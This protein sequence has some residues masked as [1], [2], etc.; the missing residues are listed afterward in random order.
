MNFCA[1]LAPAS[2]WSCVS[3]KILDC[4][5]GNSVLSKQTMVIKI[6]SV[7]MHRWTLRRCFLLTYVRQCQVSYRIFCLPTFSSCSLLRFFIPQIAETQSTHSLVGLK[8]RSSSAQCLLP[9]CSFSLC[10]DVVRH[11]TLFLPL[12]QTVWLIYI[13][14]CNSKFIIWIIRSQ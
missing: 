8:I 10:Q 3:Y 12:Q 4:F 6:R 9:T 13:H 2:S 1:R 11:G 5:F 7:E 14:S